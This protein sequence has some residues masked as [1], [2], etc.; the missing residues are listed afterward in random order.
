MIQPQH[1]SMIPFAEL[2][3]T[4]KHHQPNL[5]TIVK[6]A[7]PLQRY[8]CSRS[9]ASA[10]LKTCVYRSLMIVPTVRNWL[11]LSYR[12]CWLRTQPKLKID[13]GFAWICPPTW[14]TVNSCRFGGGDGTLWLCMA[15][16]TLLGKASLAKWSTLMETVIF[17]NRAQYA[18]HCYVHPLYS[19]MHFSK[20]FTNN[21]TWT[22]LLRNYRYFVL[23]CGTY[24]IWTKKT[25]SI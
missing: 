9:T 20:N 22:P 19:S 6:Q 18:H 16:C 17:V 24:T 13:L 4:A 23:F 8:Y 3:P 15:Q 12:C 21:T 7:V 10:C 11:S 1:L 2:C 14:L 25:Y 5:T